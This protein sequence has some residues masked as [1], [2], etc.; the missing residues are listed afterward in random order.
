MNKTHTLTKHSEK[1][2]TRTGSLIWKKSD[3]PLILKQHPYF[4]NPLSITENIWIPPFFQKFRKFKPPSFY[5]GRGGERR[6][7]SNYENT[8]KG[9]Y[10]HKNLLIFTFIGETV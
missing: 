6:G 8:L 10:T 5:E 1:D 9:Y 4:T 7:C 3:N 2:S